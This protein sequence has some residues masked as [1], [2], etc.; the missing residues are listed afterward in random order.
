[1]KKLLV[2]FIFISIL[3]R[4]QILYSR[5]YGSNCNPAIIFIHGGPSGNSTLFESTT[6]KKMAEKGFFVIVYDRRGEGRSTDPTAKFTYEESC[7]DLNLIYKTYN[8]QQASIIAHSFGGLVATL[9]TER[10]PGKVNKLILAGAL[11]SQQQTYNHI[12]KTVKNI[13][14]EKKDTLMLNKVSLV[15]KLNRNSVEYRNECFALAEGNNFFKMPYPTDEANTLKQE[16]QKSDYFHNNIRNYEAPVLFYKNES[17]NNIDNT[18]LLK[19]LKN[20]GVEIYGIYGKN[21]GIFSLNQLR[22]LK[23]ITGNEN[24][25]LI[26]NCSH[27]LFVDQQKIFLET[28]EKWLKK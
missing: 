15:E 20:D 16:Y 24:F 13:Y 21:D 27:F 25:K 22:K 23:K 2:F 11:F 18:I 7:N 6:A 1:M 10:N 5:S 4:G 19:Y 28:V 26:D 17:K 9:F 14:K 12:L 8:I 3:S